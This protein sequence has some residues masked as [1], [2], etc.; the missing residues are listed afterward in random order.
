[1]ADEKS[2]VDHGVESTGPFSS[3][4]SSSSLT[5]SHDNMSNDNITS[6]SSSSDD[7]NDDSI[8]DSSS[9]SDED[10]ATYNEVYTMFTSLTGLDLDVAK[11]I[12]KS[13]DYN[14]QRAVQVTLDRID[15]GE[16]PAIDNRR[17]QAT[18]SQSSSAA[19]TQVP[20]QSEILTARTR[21]ASSSH[22]V[23]GD[24]HSNAPSSSSREN[25]NDVAFP[26][27][28]GDS[29]ML[30]ILS[31]PLRMAMY[32]TEKSMN[33]MLGETPSTAYSVSTDIKRIT[34]DTDAPIPEMLQCSFRQ[35]L[36]QCKEDLVPLVVYVHAP[37]HGA[38]ER[39][40]RT[41]IATEEFVELVDENA[42]FYSV[43][44]AS[45]QGVLVE[46][47]LECVTYPFLGVVSLES[48]RMKIV[49][50]IE[51]DDNGEYTLESVLDTIRQSLNVSERG[52]RS[53]RS[54]RRD[55]HAS[56]SLREEQDSA[57]EES[58]RIDAEKA[59]RE[60]ERLAEEQ[61][62]REREEEQQQEEKRLRQE[63][64][65]ALERERDALPVEP[66]AGDAN[67]CK[68]VIRL[69]EGNR[70]TRYFAKDNMIK[71][72]HTYV[73]TTQDELKNFTLNQMRPRKAYEDLDMTLSDAKFGKNMLLFVVDLDA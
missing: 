6:S 54:A 27:V 40:V 51:F 43:S 3:A 35:A 8:N 39:F 60:R 12:L 33:G 70:L 64:K 48:N 18:S 25:S 5:V 11:V 2:N 71:H 37:Y 72:I 21:N 19:F 15:R 14:L 53:A 34:K 68:V 4:S 56:Q 29:G 26:S 69:P 58:L 9:D 30:G 52:L 22:D 16:D 13:Y 10:D 38:T 49:K 57:Y 46:E 32:V 41:V 31:Y 50:R 47:D 44:L 45:K 42:R 24:S 73:R 20:T 36:M 59:A 66:D 23:D 7:N 28:F 1:M 55:R 62:E 65:L 61:R 67:A 63:E 17:S